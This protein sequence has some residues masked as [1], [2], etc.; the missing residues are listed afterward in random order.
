MSPVPGGV[1]AALPPPAVI[2]PD[3]FE[4]DAPPPGLGPQP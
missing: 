4:P 2:T 1:D 3:A